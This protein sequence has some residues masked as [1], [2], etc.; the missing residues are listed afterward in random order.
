MSRTKN[1]KTSEVSFRRNPPR[2]IDELGPEYDDYTFLL[3]TKMGKY[4]LCDINGAGPYERP[5][6]V[7]C[8]TFYFVAGQSKSAGVG[9]VKEEYYKKERH[10]KPAETPDKV[11]SVITLE[12]FESRY[13]HELRTLTL[14]IETVDGEGFVCSIRNMNSSAGS[15]KKHRVHV[16]GWLSDSFEYP[17]TAYAVY[18]LKAY[19]RRMASNPP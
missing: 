18:I 16:P 17:G 19:R 4:V 3:I 10:Q 2:E 6:R 12:E 5:V 11:R 7:P 9:D 1:A 8:D 15:A 14:T 13:P